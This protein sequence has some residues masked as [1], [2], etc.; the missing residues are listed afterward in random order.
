MDFPKIS[1]IQMTVF[2]SP[3]MSNA[4]VE[5]YNATFHS[6]A[7]MDNCEV[8]LIFDN[9][10][11][12]DLC[13]K[14]LFLNSP[15]YTDLN[16]LLALMLSSSTSSMRFPSTL[17]SG[18]NEMHTNLIAYPRIH[19]ALLRHAPIKHVS[20]ACYDKPTVEQ[21]TKDVLS[22]DY[23]G[24]KCD[25]QKGKFIS[26]ILNYRGLVTPNE[27]SSALQKY[28]A[29]HGITFVDWSPTGF[30]IGVNSQMPSNLPESC[31]GCAE[32]SVTLIGCTTAIRHN[33]LSL[34]R[35]FDLLYEKKSFVHWFI[36]EGLEETEFAESR[37]D[38]QLLNDDYY[39]IGKTAA[40][41][42]EEMNNQN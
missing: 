33:M 16:R 28:R 32:K 27:I 29:G 39:E 26:I 40:E 19:H 6:H 8:S 35:K 25:C 4:V 30:K 21:I 2:P 22:K 18:L 17:N 9:E 1:R 24:L 42:T 11:L 41:L 36:N 20:R 12:Y 7:T 3:T 13:K 15:N 31:V 38:L 14:F 10:G 34:I 23:Q 5:P 37:N